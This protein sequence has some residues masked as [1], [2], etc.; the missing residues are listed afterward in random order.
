MEILK[1]A[2]IDSIKL[3]PV[4]FLAYFVIELIEYKYALKL[5]QRLQRANKFASVWGAIL[6]VFPQCGFSSLASALFANKLIGFGT[7]AAVFISTSDEAV[8]IL[9]ADTKNAYIIIQLILIKIAMAIICG[10]LIDIL[11]KRKTIS[12]SLDCHSHDCVKSSHHHDIP[13][14][15]T[16]CCGHHIAETKQNPKELLLHPIKHTIRITIYILIISAAIGYIFSII[17]EDSIRL[18]LSNQGFLQIIFAAIFGLIPNC[19]ASVT[20]TDFYLSGILTF[21]AMLSGL[22]TSAGVGYLVLFRENK[23]TKEN[24]AVVLIVLISAVIAGMVSS[25]FTL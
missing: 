2:L 22:I 18:F 21:P 11:I 25:F 13:L 12:Q 8:P 10:F 14:N 17:S 16:G 15:E 4:L 5:R 3:M 7:I 24:L 6:G 20:I 19:I 9:L 1:E 23:N